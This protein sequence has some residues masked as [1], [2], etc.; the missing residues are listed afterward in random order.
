MSMNAYMTS[1][2]PALL[3]RIRHDPDSLSTYLIDQRK[4]SDT[5]Q[6]HKMWQ[7]L[8]FMLTGT[9]W[10]SDGALGQAVL[11][12]EDVGPSLGYGPARVLSPI[13]VRETAEALGTISSGDF[14]ARFDP[15]EMEAQDIYPSGIWEREKDTIPNELA[16][17]F[18]RLV[19]FYRA[20]ASRNEGALLWMS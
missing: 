8:H 7:A 10:E 20:A 16:M 14:K 9:A 12:G 2:T 11:G 4:L 1:L 17:L 5:L 19:A 3:E 18:E 6:L 15:K 13:A